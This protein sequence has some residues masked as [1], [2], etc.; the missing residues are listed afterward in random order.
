M[1]LLSIIENNQERSKVERLYQNNKSIMFHVAYKILHDKYLAE[2][3]VSK[4]L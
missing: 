1:F 2:D 4:H 3:A